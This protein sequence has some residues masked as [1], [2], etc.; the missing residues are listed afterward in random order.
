MVQPSWVIDPLPAGQPHHREQAGGSE[1]GDTSQYQ[2]PLRLQEL[3]AGAC[4]HGKAEPP[5]HCLC[6]RLLLPGAWLLPLEV[7]A[8]FSGNDDNDD[9][10]VNDFVIEYPPELD[11][12]FGLFKK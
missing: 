2:G 1:G 7:F 6:R 9:I 8:N 11:Y 4:H 3:E 10:D 12:V 5:N